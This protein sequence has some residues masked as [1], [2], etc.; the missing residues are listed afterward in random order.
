MQD[1]KWVERDLLEMK[2]ATLYKYGKKLEIA[3]EMYSR[4]LALKKRLEK[5]AERLSK[6]QVI[7]TGWF[8]KKRQEK[9]TEQVTEKIYRTEKIV[10]EL[11]ELKERYMDEFKSQREACGM[12]DHSF[13]DEFYCEYPREKS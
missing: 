13:I 1:M 10:A 11:E 6:E 12:M 8:R 2:A 9:L 7:R 4:K 5:I 3:E